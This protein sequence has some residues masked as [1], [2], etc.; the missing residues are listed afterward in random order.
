MIVAINIECQGV[1]LM[2]ITTDKVVII[3]EIP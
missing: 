1:L 3:I 2:M